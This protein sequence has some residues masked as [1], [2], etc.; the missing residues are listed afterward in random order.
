D[1]FG[2]FPEQDDANDREFIEKFEGEA[3][4]GISIDELKEVLSAKGF[5][6]YELIQGDIVHT[7]PEYLGNH[8]ELKISL[9]HIDVDVYKPTVVILDHLFD[10]IVSGGL[11]VFDDFGTVA[12]E[13]K[14]IDE[15]FTE[16]D[17]A[18][19]KLPISHIPS[20]LRK[21]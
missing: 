20:Y 7:I 11:V 21:K 14:A 10:K 8:P 13:T 17:G 16:K 1:A 2:K 4:C 6:N 19:E 15:F 18:I 12:G 3:G 9:L 5:E